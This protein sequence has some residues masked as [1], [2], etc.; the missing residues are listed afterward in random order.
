MLSKLLEPLAHLATAVTLILLLAQFY[1]SAENERRERALSYV[2]E[3][4]GDAISRYRLVITKTWLPHRKLTDAINKNGGVSR[5]D[6]NELARDV[7]REYDTKNPEEPAT[8]AVQ[9]MADF[10]DQVSIC[11]LE[12]VCDRRIVDSYFKQSATEF[13]GVHQAVVQDLRPSIAPH[14][15]EKLEVLIGVRP[16]I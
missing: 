1:Q 10:Y 12:K 14:L 6:I 7:I 5:E 11:A 16:A 2:H 4:N 13:W 3:F 9:G 15:G 8:L